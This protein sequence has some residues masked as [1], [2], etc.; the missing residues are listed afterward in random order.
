MNS[1]SHDKDLKRI[2]IF[3]FYDSWIKRFFLY[4][5]ALWADPYDAGRGEDDDRIAQ[6]AELAAPVYRTYIIDLVIIF[7]VS[8]IELTV[9]EPDECGR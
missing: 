3:I 6:R 2:L 9:N 5:Q 1:R 8:L 4:T 7:F